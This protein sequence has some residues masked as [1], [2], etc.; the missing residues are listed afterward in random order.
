VSW[1][2][3]TLKGLRWEP[4]VVIDGVPT[5]LKVSIEDVQTKT[6]SDLTVTNLRYDATVPDAIV[7][8]EGI[9]SA[10]AAPLWSSLAAAK[11]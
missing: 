4:P 10:G 8:P 1:A 3:Y 5:S 6:R 11:Q 7:T 2:N 9:A